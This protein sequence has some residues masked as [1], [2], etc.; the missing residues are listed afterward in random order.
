MA[1]EEK[2]GKITI[3]MTNKVI[4][5]LKKIDKYNNKVEKAV[6]NNVIKKR[7]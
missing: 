1:E 2:K 7:V 4:T 6:I 3:S 5:E